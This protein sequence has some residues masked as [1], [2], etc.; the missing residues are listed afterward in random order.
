MWAVA[1]L[2]EHRV[3]VPAVAGSSPVR[4]PNHEHVSEWPKEAGCN[5]VSRWFESGRALQHGKV[6]QLVERSVEARK[7]AGSSPAL[8]T[9]HY[10]QY[11]GVT[12]W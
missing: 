7:V 11:G 9:N 4:P 8:T 5:P 3:V 10:Y 12:Q 1:Q 2:A 6:A